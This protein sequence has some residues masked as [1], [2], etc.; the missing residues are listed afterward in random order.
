[1]PRKP[2]PGARDRILDVAGRL[3]YERGVHAVGM[4]QIVDRCGCGKNLLY[5][6]FPSKDDLVVAWLERERAE[7][8]AKQAAAIEP[9]DGDPVAQL[10]SLVRA[11]VDSICPG[12]RGCA[13]RN[14]LNEF[15]DPGHPARQVVV[16]QQR[17][18][19]ALL[20]DLAAQAG[21]DDPGALA[22]RIVLVL[23]GLLTSGT[24][25]GTDGPAR[26]G[27]ELAE[28]I[29]RGAVPTGRVPG[30]RVRA[31]RAPRPAR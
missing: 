6:E 30:G 1:M 20:R 3:F 16:A 9:H 2:A 27:V 17:T 26:V 19:R 7:L 13:L 23:D 21:A 29:I 25:L 11:E 12:F 8:E 15:P 14:T 18:R 31:G 28:Q 5:R 10:M 22:D 24:V 4:Q